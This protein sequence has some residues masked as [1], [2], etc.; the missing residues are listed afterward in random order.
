MSIIFQGKSRCPLCNE[1]L[2]KDRPYRMIPPLISNT[3]D[4]LFII[5]DNG[6]HQHCLKG[7]PLEK[8]VLRLLKNYDEHAQ[9]ARSL[10]DSWGETLDNP[11]DVIA[12]GLLTS[13][14]NEPLAKFSFKIVN[15]KRLDEWQDRVAF[16]SEVRRF[17]SLGKWSHLS[18]FN[19]LEYL[20]AEL[21]LS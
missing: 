10:N 21:T 9:H 13:D 5:S 11:R 6:V 20:I 17:L 15:R 18:T 19:Y 2:D 7:H 1:P 8:K 3:K 12:I 16:L 4:E 14:E